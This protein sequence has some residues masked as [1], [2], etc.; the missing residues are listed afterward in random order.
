MA[1][2]GGGN[3]YIF[4]DDRGF[5]Y[6]GAW[7]AGN[8]Y[9]ANDMVYDGNPAVA[10]LAF[11]NIA[12]GVRPSTGGAGWARLGA[13]GTDGAAGSPGTPGNYTVWLFTRSS[14]QPSS[15]TG[16]DISSP[17]TSTTGGSSWT[18][19]IS[20][21]TGNDP[22][23]ISWVRVD[24]ASDTAMGFGE[25]ARLSGPQGPEGQIGPT[26]NSVQI[27]YSPDGTSS[28]QTT[29]R[30]TDKYVQFRTGTGPD[31]GYRVVVLSLLEMMDRKEWM[32]LMENL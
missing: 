3:I 30:S 14:T 25:V 9:A 15:P 11:T 32:V 20:T 22:L 6:R 1:I 27:R 8:T 13:R 19:D 28:W 10:Y 12:A 23:W 17:W 16:S 26:G 24:A 5:N 21:L 7:A 18:L 31:H 4:E 2:V 29:P